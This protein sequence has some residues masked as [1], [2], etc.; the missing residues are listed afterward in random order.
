VL[1]GPDYYSRIFM[2]LK[3][4]SLRRAKI[5]FIE[6]MECLP[7]ATLP[8]GNE[9]G[10]EIKLD[11]FR[12]E[13]V[14]KNGETTL[15]SRRGNVLKKNLPY[16]AAALKQLPD[17]KIQREDRRDQTLALDPGASLLR[18]LAQTHESL[19]QPMLRLRERPRGPPRSV[20]RVELSKAPL[21]VRQ[22]R[23]GVVPAI[24]RQVFAK[25]KDLKAAKCSF[26]N[27]PEQSKGR[28]GQGLTAE[29]MRS[30]VWLK[31]QVVVRI[32]LA[33]WTG[34]DKLRHTKFIGLREDKDPR[35][36]ARET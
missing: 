33:E 13:A 8:E 28:W 14:K 36:V 9:W 22:V 18:R 5:G 6:S 32:E 4:R 24:R 20:L 23:A 19:R 2:G 30:C 3:I 29:K 1:G 26:V 25:I 21:N 35:K 27:L 12:L 11:G 34:A 17:D 16:I 15:Y 31:P 10:Y 7:V